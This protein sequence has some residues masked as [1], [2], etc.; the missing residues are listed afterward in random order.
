MPDSILNKALEFLGRADNTSVYNAI[1]HNDDISVV[2]KDQ[3]TAEKIQLTPTQE[4]VLNT[5]EGDNPLLT[6]D[7]ELEADFPNLIFRDTDLDRVLDWLETA[8]AV[9]LD[10]ETH[11]SEAA[12]RKEDRKKE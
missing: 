9:A 11:G 1:V 12:R 5:P 10:I 2:E 7:L 4:Y 8:E 6:A 3:T